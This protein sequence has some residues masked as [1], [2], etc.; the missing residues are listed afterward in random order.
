LKVGNKM[1]YDEY[2]VRGIHLCK[3]N[4]VRIALRKDGKT[5]SMSYP[6]YL[7]ERHL[8]RKLLITEEV[9]HRDE[10][11]SNNELDNL[12]V[13]NETDHRKHHNPVNVKFFECPTCEKIFK[14]EG[15]KLHYALDNRKRRNGEGPFCSRSCAGKRTGPMKNK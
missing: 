8:G 6:R 9:H 1:L 14:L 11:P 2:E 4:R 3:D 7:M 10:N 15:L 5:K 13:M 12:E